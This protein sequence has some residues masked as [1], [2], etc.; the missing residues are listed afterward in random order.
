MYAKAGSLGDTH[1]CFSVPRRSVLVLNHNGSAIYSLRGCES[2]IPQLYCL[3]F[4]FRVCEWWKIQNIGVLATNGATLHRGWPLKH[5]C[6][7]AMLSEQM[8]SAGTSLSQGGSTGGAGRSPERQVEGP[9]SSDP[10]WHLPKTGQFSSISRC[11]WQSD[12]LLGLRVQGTDCASLKPGPYLY[13]SLKH[14]C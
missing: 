7:A 14:V 10:L 8:P 6:R 5:S 1:R 9:R 4:C 3:V 13:H 2:L 12:T 11:H